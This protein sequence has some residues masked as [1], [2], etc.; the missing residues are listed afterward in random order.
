MAIRLLVVN[1]R[2]AVRLGR[3]IVTIV[4]LKQLPNAA[5]KVLLQT[6]KTCQYL[7]KIYFFRF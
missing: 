3:N 5:A 1:D 2:F 6:A 4:V 7:K